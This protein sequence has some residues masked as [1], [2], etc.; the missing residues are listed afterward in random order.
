VID[1]VLAEQLRETPAVMPLN[2]ATEILQH[3]LHVHL[4]LSPSPDFGSRG[5][6]L[7][8]E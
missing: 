3:I 6:N 4:D 7:L 2:R 5:A 1:A 8:L